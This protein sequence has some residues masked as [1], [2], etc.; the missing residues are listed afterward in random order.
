MPR[1]AKEPAV[2][3]V[4]IGCEDASRRFEPGDTLTGTEFEPAIIKNFLEIGVI[5][6]I[7]QSEPEAK[8]GGKE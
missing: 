1:K 6:P 4:L 8:D 2:Y 3:K 5:E 7:S